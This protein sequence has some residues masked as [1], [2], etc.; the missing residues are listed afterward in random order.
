MNNSQPSQNNDSERRISSMYIYTGRVVTL[1]IDEI[2]ENDGTLGK[3]EIIEHKPAVVILAYD[4]VRDDLLFIEQFR[5][6]TGQSLLEVP[7]GLVDGQEA[8]EQTA[9]RELLEETGYEAESWRQLGEYYTSP[10]FTDEKHYL[11]LAENLRQV[12][13]VQD[14]NEIS[15][16]RHISRAEAMSLVESGGIVD[17]KS[18]LALFR[19]E[20]LLK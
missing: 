3:R 19:L 8:A 17:G 11:F 9:R 12:S 4:A 18:I 13:G 10:G 16:L 15:R 1:R 6:A 14:T 20:Y 7:A 2:R 5:D